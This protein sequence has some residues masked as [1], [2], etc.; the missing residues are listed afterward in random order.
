MNKIEK[1]AI[2]TIYTSRLSTSEISFIS[3]RSY[4]HEYNNYIYYLYPYK[5]FI[6][7]VKLLK[8]IEFWMNESDL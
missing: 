1:L 5:S 6:P 7:I 4:L 8:S 2:D 3:P